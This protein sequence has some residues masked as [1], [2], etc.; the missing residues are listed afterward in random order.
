MNEE[1]GTSLM[2]D[3]AASTICIV[4]RKNSKL[5]LRPVVYHYYHF[6]VKVD[7][8]ISGPTEREFPYA[9]VPQRFPASTYRLLNADHDS[10]SMPNQDRKETL[11]REVFR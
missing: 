3:Y 11:T 6:A 8:N 10:K 5:L 1:S 9:I 4:L 7:T 2:S